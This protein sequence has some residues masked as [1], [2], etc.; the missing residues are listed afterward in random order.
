MIRTSSILPKGFFTEESTRRTPKEQ[1]SKGFK[2]SI[3]YSLLG[4]TEVLAPTSE[5]AKQEKLFNLILIIGSQPSSSFL[6]MEASILSFSSLA[7][8]RAFV[9]C[10]M[11]ARLSVLVWGSLDILCNKL[12]TSE[13]VQLS[14]S[15]SLLSKVV[16]VSSKLTCLKPSMFIGVSY[17][18]VEV[19]ASPLIGPMGPGVHCVLIVSASSTIW[20]VATLWC[21]GRLLNLSSSSFSL[22]HLSLSLA[23]ILIFSLICN[24]IALIGVALFSS[25]GEVI[26]LSISISR[27][28]LSTFKERLSILAN[29]SSTLLLKAFWVVIKSLSMLS[30][31]EEGFLLLG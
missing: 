19:L 3:S 30:N 4:I 13:R 18:T 9:I 29:F 24:W 22:A 25:R 31:S 14:K 1:G 27:A 21:V 16:V 7:L 28:K 5:R 23:I 11:K 20:I 26:I 2:S 10:F 6:G 12:I 8:I 17:S 15:I